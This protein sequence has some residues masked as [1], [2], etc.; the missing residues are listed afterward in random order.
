[1]IE[2]KNLPVFDSIDETEFQS[3]KSQRFNYTNPLFQCVATPSHYNEQIDFYI[4]EH[5]HEDLEYLIV[6]DGTLNYN[7]NGE[8]IVLNKGEGILVN[9]KRIHSNNSP[10][11]EHAFFVYV[12][13]H[14]TYLCAS[15]YIE[16]KYTAPL[17]G[18]KSFDYLLLK[19]DDWTKPILDEFYKLFEKK[20]DEGI[21]LEIIEMSYRILRY[22][23]KN[24]KS[25]LENTAKPLFYA[26]EF[27]AM[28]SYIQENYASKVSVEEI[29]G[30]GN[31]G[32]TLCGKLFKKYTNMTPGDYLI[33]YRV[34]KGT[35]MLKDPNQSITDI[36]FSLGFTGASHFTKTFRELIGMTPNQYRKMLEG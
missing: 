25:T 11:G 20:P 18:P 6:L 22:L 33:H 36:A 29:A 3:D 12:I 23:Y 8:S 21:E 16:Q 27:K 15:P 4:P 2:E 10:K 1:M 26:D 32:K 17:I 7:V 24:Y 28:L 30:A 5:W 13:F 19:E 35:E 9:S 31:V 14:P 34:I